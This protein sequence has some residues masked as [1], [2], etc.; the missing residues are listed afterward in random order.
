MPTLEITTGGRTGYIDYEDEADLEAKLERARAR[1]PDLQFAREDPVQ[2]ESSAGENVEDAV[3]SFGQGLTFNFQDEL[4]AMVAGGLN[5]LLLSDEEKGSLARSGVDIG[6]EGA[7][8]RERG[9][10]D[11]SRRRSPYLSAGAEVAGGFALPGLGAFKAGQA[12]TSALPAVR[13]SLGLAAGGAAAAG[14]AGLGA[15][16]EESLGGQLG[17]TAIGAGIGA[18]AAPALGGLGQLVAREGGRVATGIMRRFAADPETAANMRV[19][20][21]LEADGINTAAEARELLDDV[22]GSTLA[23][24]GAN[25]REEGVLAAKQPGPARQ[26]AE[27]IY[28]ARQLGQQDRLN[29]AASE[30]LRANRFGAWGDDYYRFMDDLTKGR[31][32]QARPL[33]EQ[34]YERNIMPT[35]E[36]MRIANTDAFKKAARAAMG[37]MRNKLDTFGPA[38]P[39]GA[40]DGSVSTQFMDQILR[41]LRDDANRAFRAGSNEYGADVNNIYKALREE[42]LDQNEYLRQARGIWAGA[43]QLEEAADAGRG[44]LFGKK[45]YAEDVERL[46][47]DMTDGEKDAFTIGLI[48][49]IMD[50]LSDATETNDAGRRLFNSRRVQNVLREAFQDEEAFR[51]FY[52]AVQ[53]ESRF[54]QT[55]NRVTGGSPTAQLL[56]SESQGRPADTS[57]T[58]EGFFVNMLRRLVNETVDDPS[59]LG[60]DDYE[61]MGGLLFDASID[62]E[63]LQRIFTTAFANRMGPNTELLTGASGATGAL[64]LT[65]QFVE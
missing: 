52:R 54:Q 40:N 41:E 15:S 24:I 56:F 32:D 58:V 33:Y 46:L 11:Q 47:S 10:L 29:Q 49:G 26:A 39:P 8:E 64:Y 18:V 61:R 6:Y 38:R 5:E 12:L 60:P 1:Y 30:G 34:A 27:E 22:P 4:G 45:Q 48:R 44:L 50:R 25:L 28:G 65:D 2:M 43:R 55:R 53:R 31:K 21:A 59:Q 57:A 35:D 63:Q 17:D 62:D 19:R 7:L 51:K 13:P 36:I 14:L 9:R 37:N 23:D 20:Q 3:R 42:V 16:E